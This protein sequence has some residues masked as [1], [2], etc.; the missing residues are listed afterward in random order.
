[1]RYEVMD[2]RAPLVG[3]IDLPV[4]SG[5]TPVRAASRTTHRGRG[6]SDDGARSLVEGRQEEREWQ[7][8]RH[9]LRVWGYDALQVLI[10]V[11]VVVWVVLHGIQ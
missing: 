5:S 8:I 11:V 9:H 1:M 3:S 4:R 10:L 6:N 2:T 7:M